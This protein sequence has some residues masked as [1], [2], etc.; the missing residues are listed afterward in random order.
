MKKTSGVYTLG[1]AVILIITFGL[2]VVD[3]AHIPPG[4]HF[5]E[6]RNMIRAWRIAGGY[7][8]PLVFDDIPEPFDAVGRGIFASMAGI[9]PFTL[10]LFTVFLNIVGT[11]AVISAARVLNRQHVYRDTIALCAG[12]AFAVIP[13][14]VVIGRAIYRANWIP[15][16]SMLALAFLFR[17]MHARRTRFFVL[18]GVFTGLSAMFYLGGLAFPPTLAVVFGLSVVLKRQTWPGWRKVALMGMAASVIM[19]P[20]VYLYV[21]VPDWLTTR[22]DDLTVIPSP[23]NEPGAFLNHAWQAVEPIYRANVEFF[24]QYNTLTDP[25]LN[26]ALLVLLGIGVLAAVWRW[27]QPEA[28]APLLVG[29]GF[30]LPAMLTSHPAEPIR[31]V[32]VFGPL[33]LLVGT[34]FGVALMLVAHLPR[35]AQVGAWAVGGLILV[36]SPIHT[37]NQ[38]H[39]HFY[40]QPVWIKDEIG[41]PGIDHTYF[42]RLTDTADVVIHAGQP[43]YFPVHYLNYPN[44]TALLRPTYFPDVQ[45]YAGEPLPDGILFVPVTGPEDATYGSPYINH[46]TQY[47]VLL[48][49]QRRM[50]LLPPLD[51]AATTELEAAVRAGGDPVTNA[52]GWTLGWTRPITQA[53]NPF[54]DTQYREFGSEHQPLA[55]FDGNL[56]LL[57]IAAESEVTPGEWTPVTV[58][59]RLR[60]HTHKDYF[61]TL[62]IIEPQ[63]VNRRG[64]QEEIFTGIFHNVYP[65]P[66]WEPGQVIAERRWINVFPD[67]PP[68]G[69]RF[70]VVVETYPGPEPVAFTHAANTSR[71][72]DILFAGRTVVPLP[73]FPEPDS[74][75]T[76]I[77]AVFADRIKLTHA[78]FAPSPEQAQPGDR[79]DITLFWE[80]LAPPPADYTIFVHLYDAGQQ[81]IAQ[82]DAQ[83]LDGRYPS[84]TW[85][86]GV[87]LSTHYQLT[88]PENAQAPFRIVAGMYTWPDLVRLPVTQT[89]SSPDTANIDVIRLY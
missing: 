87:K 30:L 17:A 13:S 14:S 3:L 42:T 28:L 45:P 44:L 49:G 61:V 18:A 34:G 33:A 24:P 57:D 47:A 83:P 86:E 4:L 77:N 71:Y 16:M 64:R 67:A 65:T 5:D 1:F 12:L 58:Y 40:E 59:W 36:L 39:Y 51:A 43:V 68:G 9:F 11:A 79:I 46:P 70:S 19:L 35:A 25:F 2:R 75:A 50:I 22:V 32:S 60:E 52:K 78:Q 48:P 73:P 37:Y 82:Y 56:E 53:H 8:L 26:P 7:G 10:R 23:I 80:V 72:E 20:W 55:V 29:L 15:S 54:S 85:A 27:R 88:I 63:S 6:A 41:W 62:G 38:F 74:S 21:R 31:L 89:D 66:M 81:L 76:V 69:Y 84:S